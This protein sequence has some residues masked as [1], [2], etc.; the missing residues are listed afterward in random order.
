MGKSRRKQET[1]LETYLIL[2]YSGPTPRLLCCIYITLPYIFHPSF[3]FSSLSIPI[4]NAISSCS[5]IKA[6]Q[7]KPCIMSQSSHR[8][9]ILSSRSISQTAFQSSNPPVT[10]TELLNHQRST[11]KHTHSHHPHKARLPWRPALATTRVVRAR[12]LTPTR[13][14]RRRGIRRPT[15]C[16]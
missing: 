14:S 2:H 9:A 4:N 16:R 5:P 6:N 3:S 15:R 7:T 11:P 1:N 10:M 13:R 8:N 12:A